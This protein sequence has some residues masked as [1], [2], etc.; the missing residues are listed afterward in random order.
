MITDIEDKFNWHH[1]EDIK[2]K[3]KTL[4]A[5]KKVLAYYSITTYEPE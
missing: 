2:W 5:L 3:K 4:K 1:P